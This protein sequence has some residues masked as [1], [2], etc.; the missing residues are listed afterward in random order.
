[1]TA[2]CHMPQKPL[3]N[4]YKSATKLLQKS[5]QIGVFIAWSRLNWSLCRSVGQT[6]HMSI[7]PLL[8]KGS[9]G[10]LRS[11]STTPWHNKLQLLDWPISWLIYRH[12]R[13][14]HR[15]TQLVAP[16]LRRSNCSYVHMF[17]CLLVSIGSNVYWSIACKR[18]S[19][20][21]RVVF[22]HSLAQQLANTR[23]ADLLTHHYSLARPT[24]MHRWEP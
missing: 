24:H 23:L 16:S 7:G 15:M 11:F 4:C 13:L 21:F 9:L 6:V 17:K 1:M 2:L 5:P 18:Q 8:A 10:I 3:Q 14:L 12:N 22:Y 20:H 19:W